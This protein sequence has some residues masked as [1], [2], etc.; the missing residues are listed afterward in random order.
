MAGAAV[1]GCDG[2]GLWLPRPTTP[3]AGGVALLPRLTLPLAMLRLPLLLELLA[4]FLELLATIFLAA[5]RCV[6]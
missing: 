1:L 5:A 2:F 6:L 4:D 3:H